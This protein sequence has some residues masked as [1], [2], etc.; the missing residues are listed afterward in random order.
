MLLIEGSTISSFPWN[1]L[2]KSIVCSGFCR[3]AELSQDARGLLQL[4]SLLRILCSGILSPCATKILLFSKKPFFF[5]SGFFEI[6]QSGRGY[7]RVPWTR[8]ISSMPLQEFKQVEHFFPSCCEI[9]AEFVLQIFPR[10]LFFQIPLFFQSAKN[11]LRVCFMSEKLMR[12][13]QNSLFV[14]DFP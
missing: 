14:E 2:S 7:C 6:P 8:I 11:W 12:G 9:V 13:H 1:L 4:F 5:N 10:L 3:S